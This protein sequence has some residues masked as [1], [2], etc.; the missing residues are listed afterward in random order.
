MWAPWGRRLMTLMADDADGHDSPPECAKMLSDIVFHTHLDV[1]C[2]ALLGDPPA[3]VE[4]MT[5]R[6]QPGARAARITPRTSL[7]AHIAGD[8]NCW[9]YMLSRWVTVGGSGLRARERHVHGGAIRWE[10]QVRQ[11]RLCAAC[12]RPLRKADPTV[13]R[14]WGWLCGIPKVCTGWSTRTTA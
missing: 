6:L 9:A 5:V 12:R 13:I 7:V 10:R 8:E 1:F 2:R 11:R 4:P 3:L 14:R